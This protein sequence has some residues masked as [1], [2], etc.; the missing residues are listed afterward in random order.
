MTL[1]I[2]KTALKLKTLYTLLLGVS[3]DWRIYKG[4][5]SL[6][7]SNICFYEMEI[8]CFI[9]TGAQYLH[10]IKINFGLQRARGNF[11]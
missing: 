1:T 3:C 6:S 8:Y 4:T 11:K 10:T 9:L 5:I 7:T 2:S